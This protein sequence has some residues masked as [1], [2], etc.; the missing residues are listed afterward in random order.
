MNN[1]SYYLKFAW[2]SLR[3]DGVFS[4]V[5]LIGLSV[6]LT[7]VL[8]ICAMIYN[9]YSFDKSFPNGSRIYRMNSVST[10]KYGGEVYGLTVN[11]FAPA[12]QEEVSEVAYVTRTF[13]NPAVVKVSGN[14]F[15]MDKFCW[16]D[17]DFFRIFNTPFVYGSSETALLKPGSVALSESKS[18]ILFDDRNPIGETILVDGKNEMTVQAVY[19]DFPANSSF[20][21]YSIIGPFM[22][23]HLPITPRDKGSYHWGNIGFETF[24]LL[25]DGVDAGQAEEQMQQILEKNNGPDGFF[26][27]QLQLFEKIH[28]YS[29]GYTYIHAPGDINRLKML[30]LLAAIILVVACINYMNLSTARAQKRSKDIGVSKTFGARRGNIVGRLYIETGM[31]TFIAFA[32]AFVLSFILLPIFNKLLGQQIPPGIFLYPTF[33]LGLLSVYLVTV[34]FAASYPALYLSG[35]APLTII[36]Q[37]YTKGGRHAVVRKGLSVVQFS[38]SVVLITWVF[39]IGSQMNYVT[40]KD[41]GYDVT[42]VVAVPL[43]GVSSQNDFT[44]LKNDFA[45]Q[46]NVSAVAFTSAFPLFRGPSNTFFKSHEV[47]QERRNGKQPA[48]DQVADLCTSYA[49]P[50]IVEMLHLKLIAGAIYTERKVGDAVS[51]AVINRKAAEFL[52][53]TP[54]EMIGKNIYAYGIGGDTR[55]AGVVEDFNYLDLHNP[56]EPYCFHNSW[57]DNEFLLMR[58]N[59]GNMSQ[60]LASYE[61]IFKKHFP[62]DLFEVYFPSL[63]QQKAYESDRQTNRMAV[64]FSVLA[65]LVACMGVFGLTAFMA[66]QRTK[67]IGIRKVLG[68]SVSSIISLFTNNYLRLLLI[69]L[70]IA[71]PIAWW[72]GSKYLESFAFRISLAWWMFAV[73]AVITVV[74]TLFT[75]CFQAIKAATANPVKAIKAE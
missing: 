34:F 49:T 9:E 63:L 68:A 39:V 65:I 45:A 10:E 6:G 74:L 55:V 25:A 51:Y 13:V 66:E 67:E 8:I 32:A 18:R 26:R 20:A 71:V 60:Q 21:D 47:M 52:G 2:R 11:P 16:A 35:F 41:L 24:C 72:L 62:N 48:P 56:I 14:F 23:S 36:R 64:S 75:V 73:A 40:D 59:E 15:K 5:N 31:V 70:V 38:V 17:E 28:L 57:S 53:M 58:V 19:K 4:L 1:F 42:G 46:S 12:V 44:A 54:E 33:L 3:R 37:G 27:V 61:A 22:S 69:S 30:S 50:E 7:V 43:S 29:V